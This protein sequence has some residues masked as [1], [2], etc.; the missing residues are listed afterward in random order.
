MATPGTERSTETL[1]VQ[2]RNL[3]IDCNMH[4]DCKFPIRLAGTSALFPQAHPCKAIQG[5]AHTTP[6]T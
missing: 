4:I 1:V 3:R 6:T 2:K 5:I